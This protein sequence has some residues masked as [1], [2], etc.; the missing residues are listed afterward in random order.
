[1]L[2]KNSDVTVYT[3]LLMV[4][5]SNIPFS[6][7]GDSGSLIVPD[8]FEPN[9]IGLF[10]GGPTRKVTHRPRARVLD[11]WDC[12]FPGI[13]CTGHRFGFESIAE[14]KMK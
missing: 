10:I 6:T 2:R 1:L 9:P 8:D 4:D 14:Q 13:G 3:D 12:S 5:D 11:L 7:H